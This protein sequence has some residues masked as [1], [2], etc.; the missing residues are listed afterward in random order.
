MQDT[1]K[2]VWPIN[3]RLRVLIADDNRDAADSLAFLMRIWGHDARVAYDGQAALNTALTFQPQ[4]GFLDL[5]MPKLDGYRLC[6]QIRW[7]MNLSEMVLVALTAYSDE[8]TRLRVRS[9]SF[10]YHLV[11]PVDPVQIQ[12]LLHQARRPAPGQVNARDAAERLREID[13]PTSIRKP[14]R[15]ATRLR[16][17]VPLFRQP[18]GNHRRGATPGQ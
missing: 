9:A 13:F 10:D 11:K 17:G 12:V 2:Q 8:E 5:G 15:S 18:A 6:R 3:N 16:A 14:F 4:I 7:D 1:T